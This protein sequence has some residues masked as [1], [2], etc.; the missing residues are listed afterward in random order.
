[1]ARLKTASAL[2]PG[3]RLL[4]LALLSS[5]LFFMALGAAGIFGLGLA[6][7]CL[8]EGVPARGL[9]RDLCYILWL[10]SMAFFLECVSFAGGLHLVTDNLADA[11]LY[12][13]RLAAAFFAGR[14]F[15]ASTP[16]PQLRE[17]ALAAG[18]ILPRPFRAKAALALVLVLGFVPLI[19]GQWKATLEAAKS[20]GYT[21]G[22]RPRAS[23]DLVAAF[24]RRLMLDSVGLP[25]VLAS[26]GWHG[27]GASAG[28]R[29]AWRGRDFGAALACLGILALA[30]LT[31]F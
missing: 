12:T 19:L 27:E 29:E 8:L 3:P 28:P 21:R 16:G 1:V 5:A 2:G 10:G 24:L 13:L 18:A 30:A 25:E 7:L 26:R 11:G 14:L 4:C 9:A 15:Y 31:P 23:V 17:A 20:R 22:R 6:I